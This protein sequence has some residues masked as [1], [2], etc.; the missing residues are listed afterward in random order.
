[1]YCIWTLFKIGD[2]QYKALPECC[3]MHSIIITSVAKR[4]WNVCPYCGKKA[5][6]VMWNAKYKD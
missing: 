1:M 2:Q 5:D 6:V 4:D 3:D